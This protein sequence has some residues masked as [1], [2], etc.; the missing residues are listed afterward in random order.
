ME[1]SADPPPSARAWDLTHDTTYAVERAPTP[2]PKR[3]THTGS[4]AGDHGRTLKSRCN[5]QSPVAAS[6][7]TP[8]KAATD[9]SGAPPE[10]WQ[11]AIPIYNERLV[12]DFSRSSA[13]TFHMA[14]WFYLTDGQ[15][16]GPVKPAALRH[17]ATTGY[18]KPT[19][20]VRR[21]DMGEWFEAKRVKGLF[22]TSEIATDPSLTTDGEKPLS[23]KINPN[24]GKGLLG[25]F[26]VR[27]R[28]G[29]PAWPMPGFKPV[30][31]QIFDDRFEV[32]PGKFYR[33]SR[34][35]LALYTGGLWLLSPGFDGFA[36]Q[37]S[38]VIEFAFG[39]KA[40]FF[41][42]KDGYIE[43]TSQDSEMRE[44]RIKLAITD[45]L[46]VSATKECAKL[47]EC[48]NDYRIF[49]KF[50]GKRPIVR[51][52]VC[53]HCGNPI[54]SR[55]L[56]HE[57]LS[58]C[59]YCGRSAS[60]PP[61]NPTGRN[62]PKCD[63]SDIRTFEFVHALGNSKK[64]FSMVG[65]GVTSLTSI[66]PSNIIGGGTGRIGTVSGLAELC[67]P[68]QQANWASF[69]E[70]AQEFNERI[71]PK[72]LAVWKRSWICMSCGSHWVVKA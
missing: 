41:G 64:F 14:N 59:P 2:R 7:F 50:A 47:R 67:A 27:Y 12:F 28:G 70:K 17:L 49:D 68:P 51:L 55:D 31:F 6:H 58:E 33:F 35:S 40:K 66:T 43:I 71:Y 72:K 36:I 4:S 10:T 18:L 20:K 22:I 57:T 25:A 23:N 26:S 54:D 38:K 62:C 39:E 44:M 5:T 3:P 46:F 13:P 15:Q 34:S 53:V 37:Y 9:W 42:R 63:G 29:H 45:T 16:Q 56:A 61:L 30:Q 60:T 69:S 52:T 19:D 24:E 65:G 11:I 21:D 48:L 1:T 8:E 32:T